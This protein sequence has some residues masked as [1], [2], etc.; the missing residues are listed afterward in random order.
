MPH[1]LISVNS[2]RLFAMN[3][4]GFELTQAGE[5]RSAIGVLQ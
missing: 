4:D 3:L 2:N 5:G 1:F